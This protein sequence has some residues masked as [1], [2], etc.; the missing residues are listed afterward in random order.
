MSVGFKQA[1]YV[2]FAAYRQSYQA[3]DWYLLYRQ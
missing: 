3:V 1:D 2:D